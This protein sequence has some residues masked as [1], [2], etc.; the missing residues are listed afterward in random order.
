[1]WV[2]FEMCEKSSVT[3]MSLIEASLSI[4]EL[5]DLHSVELSWDELCELL[6]LH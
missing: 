4:V 6:L 3:C 2:R 5:N 1:M